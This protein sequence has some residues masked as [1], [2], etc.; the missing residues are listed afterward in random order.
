ML[1][2]YTF[3]DF[4]ARVHNVYS[5]V[6]RCHLNLADN[7]AENTLGRKRARTSNEKGSGRNTNGVWILINDWGEE[8][9]K[10]KVAE[11][12]GGGVRGERWRWWRENWKWRSDTTLTTSLMERGENLHAWIKKHKQWRE[13]HWWEVLTGIIPHFEK[14]HQ[15]GA[16]LWI[17]LIEEIQLCVCVGTSV[18]ADRRGCRYCLSP[19]ELVG[20][21]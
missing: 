12:G 20:W 3:L 5:H 1:R 18:R 13:F 2:V 19:D 4:L 11:D 15:W 7:A 14:C 9:M 17:I 10:R 21:D 8:W 16:S 6:C